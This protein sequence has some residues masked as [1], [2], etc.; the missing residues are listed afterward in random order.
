MLAAGSGSHW[1]I[2]TPNGRP[3]FFF[4]EWSGSSKPWLHKRH[5]AKDGRDSERFLR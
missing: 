4:R 2:S 3:G 1:L 5:L